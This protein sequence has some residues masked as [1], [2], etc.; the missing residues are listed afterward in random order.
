M[1]SG[2]ESASLEGPQHLNVCSVNNKHQ[3]PGGACSQTA[4]FP[5][6]GFSACAVVH[7]APV[8]TNTKLWKAKGSS[9]LIL[10]LFWYGAGMLHGCLS[11]D[12]GN[13]L[14]VQCFK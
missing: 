14:A 7:F 1:D 11:G 8:E 13:T 2:R 5:A 12:L 9:C 10:V 4:R 6:V 3:Y